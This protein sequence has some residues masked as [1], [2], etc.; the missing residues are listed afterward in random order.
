MTMTVRTDVPIH[1]HPESLA[2]LSDVLDQKDT[3]GTNV[4]VLARE[5]LQ[6]VHDTYAA[7]NDAEAALRHAQPPGK[8]QKRMVLACPRSMRPLRSSGKQPR[9]VGRRLR[10]SSTGE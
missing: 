3:L 8:E 5:A 4:M 10:Q 2:G 7:L 6:T 9:T 1:L